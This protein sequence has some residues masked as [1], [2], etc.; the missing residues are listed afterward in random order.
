MQSII[1]TKSRLEGIESLEIKGF[2]W[3]NKSFTSNMKRN[4]SKITIQ[5]LV[6][7]QVRIKAMQNNLSW[8]LKTYFF[9]K[10]TNVLMSIK[11]KFLCWW[12]EV[13]LQMAMEINKKPDLNSCLFSLKSLRMDIIHTFPDM[14]I[15][16]FWEMF[17]KVYKSGIK[18]TE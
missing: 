9:L 16:S 8:F 13:S 2:K 5:C 1:S 3:R 7:C 11:I 15:F 18:V 14:N 4:R 12:V 17:K 6:K 10:L